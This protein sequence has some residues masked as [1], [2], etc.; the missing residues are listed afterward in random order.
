MDTANF[1]STVNMEGKITLDLNPT[2]QLNGLG[3]WGSLTGGWF[4]GNAFNRVF[5]IAIGLI[6][7]IAGIYFVFL[8]ITG[9]LMYMSAGGD[10]GKV[11][12]AQKK[13][14][15]GLIG[16]VIVFAGVLITGFVSYILGVNLL[17]PGRLL[18]NLGP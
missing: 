10:K 14:T 6:T 17:N 18:L 1:W 15:S 3:P 12:E 7:V 8:V 2:W 4:P 11:Q 16:L 13:I 9:G 5:S